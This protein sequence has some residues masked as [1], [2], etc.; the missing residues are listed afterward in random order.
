MKLIVAVSIFLSMVASANEVESQLI[1]AKRLQ[2]FQIAAKIA[3]NDVRK[4]DCQFEPESLKGDIGDVY[5]VA[6]KSNVY[7]F[8]NEN[9]VESL[10]LSFRGIEVTSTA[11]FLTQADRK[12]LRA[13]RLKYFRSANHVVND[14]DLVDAKIRTEKQVSQSFSMTCAVQK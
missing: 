5:S 9:G 6:D 3:L 1:Q 11:T 12:T 14:G 10:N 4:W 13:V 8:T 7:F 2:D